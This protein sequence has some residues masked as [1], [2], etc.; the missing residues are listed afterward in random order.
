[1]VVG[2]PQLAHLYRSCQPEDLDNSMCFQV[3]G[4]DIMIDKKFRP[5]LIEVN[6][7]PSF[8]TDSSLDYKVKKA[9]LQD[10][11]QLLN[12]NVEKREKIKEDNLKKT[13]IRIK[14]GKIV[15]MEPEEKAKL[16]NQKLQERFDFEAKISNGY[17]LIYP[18]KDAEQNQ[19]YDSFIKGA[20]EIWDMFT[21][22]NKGNKSSV[23][24][25]DRK[26]G[27]PAMMSCGRAL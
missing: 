14:T 18:A 21:T 15:K 8:G 12:V 1:M 6:Q 16:R 2:Q 27:K 11:F 20:N 3:L 10:A 22:G 17:E 4:F 25:K 9:V 13:E 23:N 26:D 5:W 24:L 7:S 19:K